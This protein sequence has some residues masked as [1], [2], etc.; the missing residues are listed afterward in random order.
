LTDELG[1]LLTPRPPEDEKPNWR[2]GGEY[3]GFED[4]PF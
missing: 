3:D 2:E 1:E 4:V